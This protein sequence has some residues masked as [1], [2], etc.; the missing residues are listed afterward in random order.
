MRRD[1]LALIVGW[2]MVALMLP[3]IFNFGITWPVA[4][5]QAKFFSFANTIGQR[6][7]PIG[8]YVPDLKLH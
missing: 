3:L 1:V 8:K 4:T 2:T 5:H 6:K 7:V